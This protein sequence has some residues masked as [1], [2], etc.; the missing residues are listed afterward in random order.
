MKCSAVGLS[1]NFS[2][3]L[4][5]GSFVLKGRLSSSFPPLGSTKIVIDIESADPDQPASQTRD[6]FGEGLSGRDAPESVMKLNSCATTW[7]H[8]TR[9]SQQRQ[10]PRAHRMHLPFT[11]HNQISRNDVEP[12]SFIKAPLA[13][14][15]HD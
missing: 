5:Q 9:E 13:T 1:D 11:V 6:E 2:G 7:L 8:P 3:D 15:R 4:I 10:I 14:R 12:L